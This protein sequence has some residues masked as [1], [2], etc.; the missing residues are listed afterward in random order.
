[1]KTQELSNSE[2]KNITLT[3]IIMSARQLAA[4]DKIRLIRIL[5]EELDTDATAFPLKSNKTCCLPTPYNTFG[6]AELLIKALETED[7]QQ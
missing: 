4:S 5:A 7:R 2:Q 6:A 1:M 3:E